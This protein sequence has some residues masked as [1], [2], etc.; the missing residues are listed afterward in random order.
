MGMA[1]ASQSLNSFGPYSAAEA[2]Y[3]K[4]NYPK[5]IEKYQEY[6]TANPQ[7]SLAPI[8]EYYVGKSYAASGD[9]VKAI[10]TFKRVSSQYPKT[11]W[12]EFAKDQLILLKAP[13][14]S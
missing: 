11:S 1:C 12:A 10:E 6:L 7:A 13:A 2:Y 3:G 5:A 4:G 8:A 14:Q 9:K